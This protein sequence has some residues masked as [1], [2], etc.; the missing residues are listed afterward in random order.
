MRDIVSS[1]YIIKKVRAKK[2]AR[3]IH[4]RYQGRKTA[5]SMICSYA[6]YMRVHVNRYNT[7]LQKDNEKEAGDKERIIY[8]LKILQPYR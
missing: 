6:L 4:I 3:L 7:M 5:S 1:Y 2:I 8:L